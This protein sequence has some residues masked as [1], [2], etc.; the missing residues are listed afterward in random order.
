MYEK[1]TDMS[2]TS[3][4][5]ECGNNAGIWIEPTF[6]HLIIYIFHYNNH[7]TRYLFLL[8]QNGP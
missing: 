1:K 4:R 8:E 7:L 6:G 5:H 2:T 3:K